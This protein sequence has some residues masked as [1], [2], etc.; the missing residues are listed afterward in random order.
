MSSQ[1]DT[2]VLLCALHKALAALDREKQVI[3]WDLNRLAALLLLS[4]EMV[5]K[6]KELR[7]RKPDA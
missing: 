6:L 1:D 3:E 7:Q 2:A 4:K 5:S